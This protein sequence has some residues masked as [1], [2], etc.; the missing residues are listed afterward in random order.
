M[1][2]DN[3]NN[4]NQTRSNLFKLIIFTILAYII[5]AFSVFIPFLGILGVALISIPV[6]KLMLEGRTWE[7]VICAVG[8][9]LVLIFVSWILLMFFCVLLIGT[10]VIY[11]LCVKNNKNPFQV[12]IYNSILFITLFILLIIVFSLVKQENIVSSFMKNY[13]TVINKLPDEPFIKQ[14]MQLMA[15]NDAQF[16]SLFEQSKSTF[17]MLPYLIPGLLLIYVFLGSLIN[18]YWCLSIFKKSGLVLKSMPVFKTW[19]VPWYLVS[20][21]IIGLIFVVIPH[22]NPVYDIAVDAVGINL[23]IIFG[24]LYTALGFSVLWNVFDKLNTTMLWRVLII[25]IISFFVILIIVIPVMGVIDVW[26]NF[27]K[28]ERR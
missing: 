19:D 2:F 23:L 11:L 14:Y 28:L 1:S 5:L 9:S 6:I 16:K 12:I 21:L 4:I 10:A 8:G 22:F 26:A 3:I 27:R 18:Y 17:M 24:L 20:G 13:F 25:L 15:I 7:S